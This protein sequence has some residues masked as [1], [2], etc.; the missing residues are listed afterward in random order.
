MTAPSGSTRG[1]WATRAGFILAAVGSA[2]GL[3]NMWRFAYKASEGGGAAF[4]VVYLL[5]V[6]LVG[7]PLMTSEFIV[8]RLAQDG[9]DTLADAVLFVP[10]WDDDGD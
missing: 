7:V 6:A 5:I 8:G 9:L 4:V 1:S 3:G 2:V 10:H